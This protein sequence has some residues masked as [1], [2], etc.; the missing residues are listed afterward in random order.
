MRAESK[1][2]SYLSEIQTFEV[3]FFQRAYVWKK[4]NWEDLFDDLIRVDQRHFLGSI[5]LKRVM[6]QG[7]LTLT[8]SNVSVID[9]QQ[10]ITTLSILLKAI[11][12]SF[13]DEVKKNAA[14]AIKNTL[15]YKKSKTSSEY[16]VKL[17][18]SKVDRI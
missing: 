8:Q 13:S 16:L 2:F 12:D 6:R 17:K 5:I 10:R 15:F 4:E 14:D 11:Y 7:G 3:P 18:H 1:S 9:G